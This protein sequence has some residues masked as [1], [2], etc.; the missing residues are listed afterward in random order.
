MLGVCVPVG[1]LE[2]QVTSTCRRLFSFFREDFALYKLDTFFILFS[3]L[4]SFCVC[5]YYVD[6]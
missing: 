3:F 2:V 5:G 1:R 4:F 6:N